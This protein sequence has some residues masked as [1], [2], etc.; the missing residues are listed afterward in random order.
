[1]ADIKVSAVTGK[2]AY[3]TNI[4]ARNHTILTDEPIEQG[5]KDLAPK[6]GELLA[7]SLASCT[8][9]TLKMYLDRK[10]WEVGDIVVDVDIDTDSPITNT[11]FSRSISFSN[12]QLDEA[13]LKRVDLI[14]N[15]C[16]I[17]KMLSN[18]IEIKTKINS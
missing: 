17:H 11:V 13:Q 9:I 12:S 14:A 2:D 1:M 5:G 3:L 18:T 7:A 8:A 15:A 4:S 16:P 6:P 10:G